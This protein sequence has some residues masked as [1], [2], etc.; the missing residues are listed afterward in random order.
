LPA[1]GCALGV[2]APAHAGPA[3]QA[4]AARVTAT[5]PVT[6]PIFRLVVCTASC[7]MRVPPVS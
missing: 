7:S 4:M 6:F 3:V 2:V 1:G 5:A